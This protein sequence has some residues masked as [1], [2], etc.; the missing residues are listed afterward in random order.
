MRGIQFFL[1]NV[2]QMYKNI[3]YLCYQYVSDIKLCARHDNSVQGVK[4]GK[5][6]LEIMNTESQSEFTASIG[7]D[8]SFVFY[9]KSV[10]RKSFLSFSN[11]R[12]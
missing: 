2:L 1:A 12:H 10:I 11:D 8:S 6:N 9:P 7:M 5:F 4:S 3:L